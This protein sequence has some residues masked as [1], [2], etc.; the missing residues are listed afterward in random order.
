MSSAEQIKTE[1]LK[2]KSARHPFCAYI[3]DVKGLEEHALSLASSL[4]E[5]VSLYYAMKA[6]PDPMLIHAIHRHVKGFEA[7]SLGELDKL[8]AFPDHQK[9][10]SGPAKTDDFLKAAITREIR[11]I[12]AESLW[13]VERI[14]LIAQML[15]KKVRIAL[16][17]NLQAAIGKARLT[18]A[19]KP[20]QFGMD[21]TRLP[22]IMEKINQLPF[23][24]I[25]GFHFHS[26]SNNLDASAHLAFVSQCLMKAKGWEA[27]YHLDLN[28]VNF[29]GGIGIHYEKQDEP[30]NWEAFSQGIHE[31]M[32]LASSHWELVFELGRYM[33]GPFGY[34]AA[35]V[36]DVKV[37]HGQAYVTIRGGSHHL[38]LPAAWKMSH[39]FEVI[40]V[41]DW[42]YPLSRP[43]LREKDVW[44]AGELCTPNDLLVRGEFCEHIRVG[45]IVLFRYAG[46]YA[47]TIS[48]HDFLSHGKPQMIYI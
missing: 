45:D 36:M 10:I 40:A 23:V 17:I 16:R 8:T 34:Y 31:L 48:H 11:M 41:D 38:R 26:V 22:E 27:H 33:A 3:Y 2:M 20:T 12:H 9:V 4:P 21:E 28:Y 43:A 14:H 25:T 46:A 6:N 44:I 39:P 32:P 13:E 35:E 47:W 19:G 15:G 29:G 1:I 5:Q 42:E 24:E 18:M 37:N 30:F 7:A